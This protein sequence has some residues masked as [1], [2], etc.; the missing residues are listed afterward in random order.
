MYTEDD[1]RKM[2]DAGVAEGLAFLENV[3]LT[4]GFDSNAVKRALIEVDE[5]EK[6]NKANDFKRALAAILS[7]KPKTAT[8]TK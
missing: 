1:L 6:K 4:H 7:G 8:T 5:E 2:F 3:L